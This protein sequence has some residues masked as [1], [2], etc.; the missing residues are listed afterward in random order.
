MDPKPYQLDGIDFLA[1][2]NVAILGDDAGLG[3]SMQMIRAAERR[4]FKRIIVLCPA[5][6]RV[7]WSIQLREW[8]TLSPPRPVYF[9]PDHTGGLLP[10][11]PLVAVV[12]LDWMQIKSKV[13]TM[14]R[15]LSEADPFD[16][17]FID[18]A[19]YLMT[20][21]ASRTQTVYGERLDLV[22]SALERVPNIWIATATLTP[23]HAGEAYT[24][25]KALFPDLLRALFKGN[26]PTHFEFKRRFTNMRP[27]PFGWQV[28]GNNADTIPALRDAIRPHFL[29]RRKADVLADLPPIATH[30][31]PVEVKDTAAHAA[32]DSAILAALSGDPDAALDLLNDPH[33]ATRRRGLGMLKAAAI[34]PW[35]IDF[36]LA[37]DRKLVLFAHHRAVLDTVV[38]L[39][40]AKMP[41]LV[42]ARIDGSSSVPDK[43]AAVQDFQTSL[44]CR[45]F[46]GQTIACNTSITLTAASDVLLLE[47]DWTP[48]NNY[49]AISRCHRIGQPSAV[50]AFFAFAHGTVDEPLVRGLRRKA[51]DF[52]DLFGVDVGAGTV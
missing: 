1:S 17:A 38:S 41:G 7:S 24:H 13:R 43:A 29:A 49:Q 26:I 20:P 50:N 45:L 18:E 47:P 19:Q 16:V 4:G 42:I 8:Q 46:V 37:K 22:G 27:T 31:L 6:G 52:Q 48:V 9:F 15:T 23:N 51:S 5:I 44:A 30:L 11:G 14:L 36:L 21:E 2:R 10:P 35:I 25:L 34:V 3:K 40:S 28:K 32:T 39:V 12:T 33:V